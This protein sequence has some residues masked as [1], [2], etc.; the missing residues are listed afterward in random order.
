M[1]GDSVLSL[2]HESTIVAIG[3]IEFAKNNNNHAVLG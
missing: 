1:C 2:Y 3:L